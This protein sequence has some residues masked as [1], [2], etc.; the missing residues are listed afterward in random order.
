M[1]LNFLAQ[2]RVHYKVLRNINFGASYRTDEFVT[3]WVTISSSTGKSL[4]MVILFF[5]IPFRKITRSP[6][7]VKFN[8]RIKKFP[9]FHKKC[10]QQ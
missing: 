4:I 1:K 10:L 6:K 7:Y 2:D 9:L 3:S 8:F 5:S